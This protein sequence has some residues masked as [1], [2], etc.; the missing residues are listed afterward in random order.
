M[1]SNI[2]TLE[3][4]CT[5]VWKRNSVTIILPIRN[6]EAH[7]ANTLHQLI[8]QQHDD[9]DVEILVA[10][11]RSTD[12][13]KEIVADF[14]KE[15]PSIKLF[16]NP[17]QLSSTARNVGLKHA[18]GNYIVIIDGH[19]EIRCRTYFVDLVS[20]FERTEAD[21][22]GRPQPLA[23]TEATVFQQSVA[24]ARNS[25]FGH[26][27]D[28]LVYSDQEE[29][30]PALSVAVAYRKEVFEKLGGF[31]SRFDAC[32]DCEMNHR[33]DQTDFQC[34]SI[35]SLAVHYRPRADIPGLFKQLS[36]YG[37]GRTRLARKHP[38]SLSFAS[39]IPALFLIGL[40]AGPIICWLIPI[41]WYVYG[42]T[43]LI[44]VILACFFSFRAAL[45]L[46]SKSIFFRLPLIFFV[47]HI[48]SGWGLLAEFLFGRKVRI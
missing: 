31:D 33:I 2:L 27:P 42:S 5:M 13:T 19:C 15:N 17:G 29:K 8:E 14:A 25:V 3:T 44:Y 37:R 4:I 6:E 16:D 35:P 22:L 39:I 46:E 41:F 12:R 24:A 40:L 10:D 23:V 48:G 18:T 11:G 1:S 28:S 7:I 38:K 32:E 34:Y 9:I 30:V 45:Q 20:A 26:H 21:C 36:R 47:I 43:L